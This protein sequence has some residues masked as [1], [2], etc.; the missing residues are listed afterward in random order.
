MRSSLES[1]LGNLTTVVV[2]DGNNTQGDWAAAIRR[3]IKKCRVVVAD[4]TGPSREVLFEAGFARGKTLI[5]IVHTAADRE[6]LPVWLTGLTIL[7]YEGGGLPGVAERIVAALADGGR[8]ETTA[9]RPAPVPGVVLWLQSR[10]ST[11]ASES[12]RLV[13]NL[14]RERQLQLRTVYPEDLY[15]FDDLRRHLNVWLF[16]G[17]IDGSDQD[18]A[19][20]FFAGDIA[21]RRSAGS[22]A[23]RG[24]SIARCAVVFPKDPT[25]EEICVADSVRRVSRDIVKIVRTEAELLDAVTTL[26][27]RHESWLMEDA[28]ASSAP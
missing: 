13:E 27:R 18:Y 11:W 17:C 6:Q 24:E 3:R 5:P 26:F 2:L 12:R 16:I 23:R 9:K 21:V 10:E 1:I 8:A 28:S 7:T 4:V 22:G 25:V 20:H 14:A 19:I 15:S